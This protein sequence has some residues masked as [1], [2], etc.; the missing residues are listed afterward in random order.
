MLEK[1]EGMFKDSFQKW[2][3]TKEKLEIINERLRVQAN[4]TNLK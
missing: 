3:E 2:R 4:A 1:W